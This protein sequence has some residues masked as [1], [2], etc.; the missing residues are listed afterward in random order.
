MLLWVDTAGLRGH[1]A[2]GRGKTEKNEESGR[3]G[4][5]F[6]AG[7]RPHLSIHGSHGVWGMFRVGEG[8]EAKTPGSL[9]LPVLDNN[10]WEKGQKCKC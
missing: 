1:A 2:P 5:G 4:E 9:R 10:H 3:Q 8:D 6:S 7:R